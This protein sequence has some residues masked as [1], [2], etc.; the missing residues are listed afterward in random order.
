MAYAIKVFLGGELQ[1]GAP[2]DTNDIDLAVKTADDFITDWD[3]LIIEQFT[4]F[5]EFFAQ[6]SNFDIS[7]ALNS[8]SIRVNSF[9]KEAAE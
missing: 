8:L 5:D 1:G 7:R 2:I 9:K 3:S 4:S 6:D